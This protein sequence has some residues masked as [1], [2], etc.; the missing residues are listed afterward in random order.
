VVPKILDARRAHDALCLDI[1]DAVNASG[2]AV[3]FRNDAIYDG[4]TQRRP[5]WGLGSPDLV[6]YLIGSG[7][8]CG[9]EVKT[10][11]GKLSREQRCWHGAA[12]RGGVL[13]VEARSV[14]EAM[15]L[16][17][18]HTIYQYRPIAKTRG[19]RNT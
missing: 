18:L 12:Q 9:I 16:L 10:G 5:P 15:W 17:K 1:R 6:G 14:D 13:V 11:D 8:C 4:R 2:L 3:L 19:R 7:R